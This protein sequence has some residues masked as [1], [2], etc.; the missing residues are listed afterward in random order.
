VAPTQAA[1]GQNESLPSTDCRLA[2]A[3]WRGLFVFVTTTPRI[4]LVDGHSMIFAWPEL[5]R[6]HAGRPA[7]ARETLVKILTDL[8]D[9]SDWQVAVVFDG[10]GERA[11]D[12][13]RPGGVRVFYSKSGQTADSVIERLTAKYAAEH[14][15]TVA[16][17]DL[18]ERT[19]VTSLG[20]RFM[21]ARELRGEVESATSA[22]GERLRHLRTSAR[23]RPSSP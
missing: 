16:T 5:S 6:L 11:S 2:S 18:M 12:D 3:R 7:S 1:A 9:A 17:E 13:S 15:V 21:G 23:Q 14:V 4:L 19:T 8:Q 22:L 10:R 20:A